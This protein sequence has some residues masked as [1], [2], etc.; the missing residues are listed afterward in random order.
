VPKK[1]IAG[2]KEFLGISNGRAYPNIF[3]V[4]YSL[5]IIYNIKK[6]YKRYKIW[7][8]I[9]LDLVKPQKS[10]GQP[11]RVIH[12]DKSTQMASA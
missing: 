3:I 10:A 6:N 12:I 5:I 4:Y 2:I 1:Y 8:D 7:G 9:K 11:K